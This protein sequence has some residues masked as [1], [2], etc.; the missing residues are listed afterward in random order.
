M[1]NR[2]AWQITSLQADIS[3]GLQAYIRL[4]D[5]LNIQGC[6]LDEC[7]WLA[8]VQVDKGTYTGDTESLE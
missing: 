4:D 5:T 8:L 7:Q 6:Y 1:L 2:A 3:C